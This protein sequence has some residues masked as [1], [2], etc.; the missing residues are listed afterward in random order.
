MCVW[1]AGILP[2]TVSVSELS[3]LH[4]AE[5]YLAPSGG[6]IIFVQSVCHKNVYAFATLT[7]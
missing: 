6:D 2:N 5:L 3:S 1:F 4:F 7:F